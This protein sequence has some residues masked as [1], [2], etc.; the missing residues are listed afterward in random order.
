MVPILCLEVVRCEADICFC[1]DR[2]LVHDFIHHTFTRMYVGR[3]NSM[4][5]SP[6]MTIKIS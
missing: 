2:G 4:A 1:C 3:G 5:I 6:F